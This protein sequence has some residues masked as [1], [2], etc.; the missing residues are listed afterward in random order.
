MEGIMRIHPGDEC[1]CTIA[2]KGGRG[3]CQPMVTRHDGAF[4]FQIAMG[5]GVLQKRR[6]HDSPRLLE[7]FQFRNRDRC[8]T[9][10]AIGAENGKARLFKP[11]QCFA[12]R[13]VPDTITLRQRH[14]TQGRTGRQNTT[15]NI[16]LEGSKRSLGLQRIALWH[17]LDLRFHIINHIIYN[18]AS[19]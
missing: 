9:V 11:R 4:P 14:Q 17:C 15:D 1:R 2:A 6:F 19:Q 3:A 7:I 13:R 12:Q 10:A 8:Y 16:P 5:Y 18:L